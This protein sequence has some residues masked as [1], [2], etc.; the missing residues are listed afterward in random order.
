MAKWCSTN[1]CTK[2]C[3]KW[4]ILVELSTRRLKFLKFCFP[5]PSPPLHHHHHTAHSHIYTRAPSRYNPQNGN[6]GVCSPGP[7]RDTGIASFASLIQ[8]KFGAVLVIGLHTCK[9]RS[10]W[11]FD[12]NCISMQ[13]AIKVLRCH[14][15]KFENSADVINDSTDC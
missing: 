2:G 1:W 9:F 4:C 14:Q 13:S 3:T 6:P 12:P 10:Q 8:W 15:C 5:P 11:K 7:F